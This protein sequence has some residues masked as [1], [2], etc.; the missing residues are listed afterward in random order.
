MKTLKLTLLTISAV[1]FIFCGVSGT[2]NILAST[3]SVTIV[4]KIKPG[5]KYMGSRTL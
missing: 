2:T 4:S 1:F 5:P 3:N